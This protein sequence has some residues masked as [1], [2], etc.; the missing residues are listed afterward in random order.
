MWRRTYHFLSVSQVTF[1]RVESIGAEANTG[2]L[3]L[4]VRNFRALCVAVCILCFTLE[5]HTSTLIRLRAWV[6]LS[7]DLAKGCG[8]LSLLLWTQPGLGG[9][10]PRLTVGLT[11]HSGMF[12]LSSPAVSNNRL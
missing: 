3:G 6:H 11:P 10:C 5:C 2:N 9:R 4:V 12:F 7:P 1:G 8:R